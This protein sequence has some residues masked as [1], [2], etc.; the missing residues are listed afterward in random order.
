MRKG[1]YLLIIIVLMIEIALMVVFGEKINAAS[2][3]HQAIVIGLVTLVGIGMILLALWD[4][5]VIGGKR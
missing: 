1:F 5:K 2:G 3:L 4:T